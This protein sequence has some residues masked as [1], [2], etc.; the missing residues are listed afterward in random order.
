MDFHTHSMFF[1]YVSID[2]HKCFWIVHIISYG[3]FIFHIFIEKSP[4]WDD[5]KEKFVDRVD[6]DEL[7]ELITARYDNFYSIAA[8][9]NI[10]LF[11]C[12]HTYRKWVSFGLGHN[13]WMWDPNSL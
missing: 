8:G 13:L 4:M 5:D 12:P 1:L 11:V 3:C 2:F 10:H 9:D 6:P 7:L